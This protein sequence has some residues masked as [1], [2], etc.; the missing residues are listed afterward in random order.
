MFEKKMA[1]FYILD[2]LKEY[3]DKDHRLSQKEIID[4][5]NELY[6]IEIERKTISST[7]DLLKD[8]G[9]DIERE[10]GGYYLAER[11]FNEH[12][13]KYLIDAIYSSKTIPGAQANE[14]SKKLYSLLSRYERK[15]Y[16]YLYKSTE[17][18]RSTNK[19]IFYNIEC[20]NEAIKEKKQIMFNYIQ[21]NEIGQ[22]C[23]PTKQ[24][25][26]YVSPYFLVN[27]FNK[28]YL[29]CSMAKGGHNIFRVEYIKNIKVMDKAARKYE[30]VSD[31]AKYNDITK[32]INDHIYMFGGEVNNHIQIELLTD[33]ASTYVMDWFG[34]NARI[35]KDNDTIYANIKCNENAFFYWALQYQEH[36]KVLNP[37]QM[38][39]RIITALEEN[40]KKYK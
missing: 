28:Y 13:I 10:N 14:L 11:E 23:E 18:N 36:I 19:E 9:Y 15:D 34:N 33:K 27:N 24:N 25:T 32:Y 16:S 6:Y 26:R 29:V 17:I 5:L 39:D 22:L 31:L 8:Y 1:M 35:Y 12:E 30:D 38:V 21:Y 20:I 7:I 2:I 4:K 3:T 37:P 40:L